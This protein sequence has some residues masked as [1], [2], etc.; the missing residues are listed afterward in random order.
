EPYLVA[1][2]G[3]VFQARTIGDFAAS[4]EIAEGEVLRPWTLVDVH[5][6]AYLHHWTHLC[7]LVA[8]WPLTLAFLAGLAHA[9]WRRSPA[10]LVVLTWVG[11]YFG[12]VGGLHAKPVRYLVPLVPVLAWLA[13]DLF[14]RL[15]RLRPLRGW[16]LA[17][18]LAAAAVAAW[19]A[20]YG[21]AFARIYA[22]EDPRVRAARWI[23]EH[24][25]P[26][27]RIVTETGGFALAHL[28]SPQRY[29]RVLLH[30]AR[31]FAAREYLTCRATWRILWRQLRQADYL[32]VVDAN[33]ILQFGAVPDLLPAA[34]EFYRRLLDGELG[35]EVVAQFDRSPVLG[36]IDYSTDDPEPSFVGYDHPTVY[37]L[38]RGPGFEAAWDAWWARLE[39]SPACPDRDLSEV[40]ARLRSGDLSGA[41]DRAR[42][43]SQRYPHELVTPL[44]EAFVQ[45]ARGEAQLER[46]AIARYQSGYA[47]PSQ[48]PHLIPWASSWS[49]MGLGADELV[50]T[51]MREGYR[52]LGPRQGRFVALQ[53]IELGGVLEERGLTAQA[54]DLYALASEAFPTAEGHAALGSALHDRGDLDG[55]TAAYTRS[56]ELDSSQVVARSN[57]AWNLYQQGDFAGAIRH[58]GRLLD[59]GQRRS[60]ILNLALSLLAHGEEAAADSL[61]AAAAA[62]I[63]PEGM[64]RLGVPAELRALAARGY[65]VPAVERILGR[66]WPGD[67]T[68]APTGPAAG[69]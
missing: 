54:A 61:Y 35:F 33:R 49:L 66:Y 57:L 4:A 13:A 16:R 32:A 39:A 51:V 11:L 36:G 53:S 27:Q 26:G 59:A 65:S 46:E 45:R 60:V 15:C 44:L 42:A 18:P 7:P 9:G 40:M 17:A 56:L 29:D 62:E 1:H 22:V 69:P 48:V 34:A 52:H 67:G 47:D 25:P 8:G 63:G 14:A 31:C 28:V 10:S 6:V 30:D 68:A 43:A 5:T 20:A 38:R 24:V 21:I 2:P 50:P 3:L 58:Y 64:G 37:V 55:S 12:L 23:A 41:A 19:T